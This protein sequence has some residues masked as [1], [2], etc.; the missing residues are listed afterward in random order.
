[1][2]SIILLSDLSASTDPASVEQQ[3]VAR[4]AELRSLSLPTDPVS[5]EAMIEGDVS[6]R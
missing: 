3:L 5:V 1:M 4:A 2:C 6:P